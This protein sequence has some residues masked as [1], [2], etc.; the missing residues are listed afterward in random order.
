MTSQ[1]TVKKPKPGDPPEELNIHFLME[2]I[3]KEI[4]SVY[5]IIGDPSVLEGKETIEILEVSK[6][7]FIWYLIL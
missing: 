7:N 3:K 1:T 4:I 2:D 5:R 6:T